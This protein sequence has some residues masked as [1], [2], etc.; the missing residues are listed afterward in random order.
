MG[1]NTKFYLVGGSV[2]DKLMN[3]PFKDLDYSVESDSFDTMREAI[4]ERGGEIF[5]ETP[6]YFTIRAKLPVLGAADYVLC[7][8]DCAYSDGRR[9]DA[10]ERGTLFDDLSRRDFTC[11]AIAQAEDGTIIDP[12]AGKESIS[13]RMLFCVGGVERLREDSLRMLRAIRFAITKGFDLECDIVDFLR[14]SENA[15]L[16]NNISKERIREELNKCFSHDTLATLSMLEEFYFIKKEIF[17][18]GNLSLDAT[19]KK[20]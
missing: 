19:L 1:N 7:R 5:L 17:A 18:S 14:D 3:L 8:K 11:N 13:R 20:R 9:P 12:F 4:L 6:K 10:V 16:L 2:R 15:K